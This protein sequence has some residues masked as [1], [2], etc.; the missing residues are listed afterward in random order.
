MTKQSIGLLAI[1]EARYHQFDKGYTLEND[2]QYQ[3]GE[4]AT[5]A[6]DLIINCRTSLVAHK[7]VDQVLESHKDNRKEIL[8]HAGALIAAEIDRLSQPGYTVIAI[9]GDELFSQNYRSLKEARKCAAELV[10]T[11]GYM[12]VEIEYNGQSRSCIT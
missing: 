2:Q 9:N 4:L 3:M 12:S 5:A 1:I 11:Q 10:S 7:I 8:A 6:V